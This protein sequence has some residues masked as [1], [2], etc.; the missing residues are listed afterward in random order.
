MDIKIYAF[1]VFQGQRRE[2]C[3]CE[4]SRS[5]KGVVFGLGTSGIYKLKSPST[6]FLMNNITLTYLSLLSSQNAFLGPAYLFSSH[7]LHTDLMPVTLQKS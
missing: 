7:F 4:T 1:G 3:F 2:S 5:C 6:I